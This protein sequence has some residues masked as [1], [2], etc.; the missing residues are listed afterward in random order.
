MPSAKMNQ[1]FSCMGQWICVEEEDINKS[2]MPGSHK[3]TNNHNH[4]N[5]IQ[6]SSLTDCM[7][8]T[9]SHFKSGLQNVNTCKTSE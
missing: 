5:I 7:N 4:S 9:M 1:S 2:A 6:V 8:F 3:H